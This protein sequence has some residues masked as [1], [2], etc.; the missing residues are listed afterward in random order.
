MSKIIKADYLTISRETKNIGRLPLTEAPE[1]EVGPKG[2]GFSGDTEIIY[3]ETKKMVEEMIANGKSQAER[4]ILEAKMEAE[5]ILEEKREELEELREEAFHEGYQKG[6]Q[7]AEEETRQLREKA[8]L[9]VREALA[10]RQETLEKGEEEIR[11][12]IL[13]TLDAVFLHALEDKET[14]MVDIGRHLLGLMKD[15]KGTLLLKA[16]REDY[17]VLQNSLE[18]LQAVLTAGRLTLR[19]DSGLEKGQVILITTSGILEVSLEENLHNI[20][21]ALM[22]VNL[23]E[24]D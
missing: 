13:E 19:E 8:D 5:S 11:Q 6:L 12:F 21:A 1:M 24:N 23:H 14:L 15:S 18:E 2:S 16:C 4:L 10:F 7:R 9:L 3:Q 22:D 17:W 20:K